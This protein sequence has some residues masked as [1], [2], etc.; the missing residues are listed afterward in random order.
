[1]K[2]L[3]QFADSLWVFEGARVNFYG[4]PFTTRMTV[5][6][7]ADQKLWIHSPEKLNSSLQ[8]ELSALGRVAFLISPNKLH[9]LFLHEWLEA[10]PEAKSYAAPGLTAKRPDLRFDVMLTEDAEDDW[11]NEIFQ[12]LFMGSPL[13]QEVVFYHKQ[14]E[15]LILTDL[16]ENVDPKTLN[17]LQRGIARMAG[18]LAPHGHMPLDWRLSFSIGSRSE[19]RHALSIMK[20]WKPKNIIVSHGNCVLGDG[21]SFLNESF[22]W[23]TE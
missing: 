16:I 20:S 23:L 5:I 13:M 7:L 8:K 15:T 10:Y 14:S 2:Q 4:F 9:H 3:K 12:T 11:S 6:R 21:E 19:A 1:M 22:S 18:I 17:I